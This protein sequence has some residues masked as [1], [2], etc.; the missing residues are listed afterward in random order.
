MGVCTGGG[1]G[2][3]EHRS[4]G[5]RDS[6][7]SPWWARTPATG[8]PMVRGQRVWTCWCPPAAALEPAS[9]CQADAGQADGHGCGE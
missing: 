5:I 6:V 7:G 2:G 3:G 9:R 4:D 8:L 1:G